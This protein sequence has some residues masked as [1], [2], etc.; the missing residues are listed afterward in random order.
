MKTTSLL[1]V[2]TDQ[3]NYVFRF[4]PDREAIMEKILGDGPI[5]TGQIDKWWQE[6]NDYAVAEFDKATQKLSGEPDTTITIE[7]V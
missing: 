2:W 1:S 6:A 3:F 7:R 4:H 5:S